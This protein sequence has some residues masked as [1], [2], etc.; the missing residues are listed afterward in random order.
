MK[1]HVGVGDSDRSDGL[2][3]HYKHDMVKRAHKPLKR[4]HLMLKEPIP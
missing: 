1:A 4:A 2:R 3:S